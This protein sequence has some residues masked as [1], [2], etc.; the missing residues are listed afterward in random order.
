[1]P[2]YHTRV[3]ADR[4]RVHAM[5]ESVLADSRATAALGLVLE[6]IADP[7]GDVAVTLKMQLKAELTRGDGTVFHGG[8]LASL[9]DVAGDMAVAVRAGGGVP[10][11]SLQVDYLRPATGPFVRAVGRLRRFGRTISVADVE[12]RGHDGRLCA[13]GRGIYS[14]RPG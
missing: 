11:I 14:S 10:T 2:S 13:L 9:V 4:A 1:M 7:E 5:I 12:V 3:H 8:P 6:E